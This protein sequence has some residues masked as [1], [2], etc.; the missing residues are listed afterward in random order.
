M[1]VVLLADLSMC[2]HIMSI[3][4]ASIVIMTLMRLE[5]LFL[6]NLLQFYGWLEQD[7]EDGLEGVKLP[8]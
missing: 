6:I 4:A 5:N 2:S 7:L 3:F 1:F 8:R